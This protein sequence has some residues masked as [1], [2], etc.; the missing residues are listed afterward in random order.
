MNEIPEQPDA[1]MEVPIIADGYLA[2]QLNF[3]SHQQA[4]AGLS[5]AARGLGMTSTVHNVLPTRGNR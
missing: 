2:D 1:V 5:T 4:R 3:A